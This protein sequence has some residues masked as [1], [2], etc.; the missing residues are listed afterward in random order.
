MAEATSTPAS[1]ALLGRA[2][3]L[4]HIRQ[5][6]RG[7]HVV[8]HVV[9][10]PDPRDHR[11]V[12][13]GLP[14]DLDQRMLDLG[15][16]FNDLFER[17]WLAD[18]CADAEADDDQDGAGDEGQ[19]PAPA[20]EGIVGKQIHDCERA[21]REEKP[22]GNAHLGPA[23]VEAAAFEGC[24]LDRQEGCPAPRAA[25]AKSLEQT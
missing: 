20:D 23:A 1:A 4:G 24:V 3:L 21:G 2:Q 14:E 12:L 6:E 9:G 13:G 22:C 7:E 19:A 11:D 10:E 8:E 25:D 5:P 17:G 15:L 18:L 16:G